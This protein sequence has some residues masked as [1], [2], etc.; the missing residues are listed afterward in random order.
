MAVPVSQYSGRAVRDSMTFRHSYRKMLDRA[1]HY[2]ATHY[3]SGVGMVLFDFESRK[4]ASVFL[5]D[6][7]RRG[8]YGTCTPCRLTH[9]WYVQFNLKDFS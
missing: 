6:C 9:R 3:C 7:G 1:I 8:I 5:N 4:E 2:G